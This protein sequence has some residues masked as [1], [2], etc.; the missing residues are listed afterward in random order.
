VFK[1]RFRKHPLKPRRKKLWTPE[2]SKLRRGV[3]PDQD[4]FTSADL[5]ALGGVT[6]HGLSGWRRA[7]LLP[8]APT[9]R[10]GARY[11]RDVARL[12]CAIGR[13]GVRAAKLPRFA[14]MI[15]F[16]L[17]EA[18]PRDAVRP[19]AGAAPSIGADVARAAP[20]A[21]AV[22]VVL[23]PAAPSAP[24]AGLDGTA[25]THIELLPGLELHVAAGAP[26]LVHELVRDI[27]GRFGK[28]G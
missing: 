4:V 5:C 27:A 22:P 1:P 8:P 3:L 19:D 21:P 9:P 17:N 11:G 12:V 10:R 18:P 24:T 26:P 28:A 23:A 7:G 15:P 13:A 14:E 20:A 25:W 2:R 6:L 16:I